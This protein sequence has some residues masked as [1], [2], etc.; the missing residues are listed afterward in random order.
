MREPTLHRSTISTFVVMVCTFLSRLFGF[1]RIAVIGAI[2][3][4]SGEADVLNAVFTIP[5]NLRKLMAEGALS[6]AFIPV[7]S[8]SLVTN[9]KETRG[10]V[11]N[12]LS[13]QALILIPLLG[14]SVIFAE[15][16][17]RILLDFPEPERI[18]LSVRLFQWMIHYLLLVSI[19][20]VFMGVLNAHHRFLIPAITPIL[21]SLSVIA[22]VLFLWKELGIFSMVLG[23]LVGGIAQVLFQLPQFFS[24]GYTLKPNFQFQNPP[25]RQILK[26]WA[27]V[28]LTASVYT[29][30]EQVAIRF[31]TALEDGSTSAMSNALVF[32]QLPF[33]IFSASVTTVLFPRM[34]RQA[35][36][37]DLSGV[38]ETVEHGLKYLILLL[39]PAAVLLS[40]LG[41]EVIT[42]A[43]QRR[44]FTSEHT[45]LTYR[46]LIGFNWGLL[47]VGAFN[48]LQRFFYSI[49]DYKTPLK[50]ALF[51]CGLDVLLSLLLKE[52]PLRVS[53]LAYANSIAFSLGLI[54]MYIKANMAIGPLN[55]SSLAKTFAKVVSA[56]IPMSLFC[57]FLSLWAREVYHRGSSFKGL[58]YLLVTGLGALGILLGIY[59]FWGIKLVRFKQKKR[60]GRNR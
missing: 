7:L 24:F 55:L 45:L 37:A 48:F 10:I 35:G 29:I 20:A 28:V 27:P 4:A 50:T 31:A 57:I 60:D 42:V 39:I 14:I 6:S 26:Q 38:R 30:N 23:V 8:K 40:V 15:P 59:A 11:Q 25:F 56:C 47:S 19:S 16:I 3:G 9:P 53:G 5:N 12:I 58:V 43:M 18:Q 33:G 34:S 52:T 54:L 2:F 49:D 46:V 13:F 41:K 1:V 21:F 36:M 32:W 51:V 44:N 17:V 22:S